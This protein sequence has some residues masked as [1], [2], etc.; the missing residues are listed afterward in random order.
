MLHFGITKWLQLC[1]LALVVGLAA[2]SSWGACS[3]ARVEGVSVGIRGAAAP[4]R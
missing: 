2:S 3:G 4:S 1:S